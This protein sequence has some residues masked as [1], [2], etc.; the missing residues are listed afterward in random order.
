MSVIVDNLH[1]GYIKQPLCLNGVSFS[2]S[3]NEVVGVL[4]NTGS[5]KTSLLKVLCKLEDQFFGSIS[6]NGKDIKECNFENLDVSFL[7]TAPVLFESKSVLKNIEYLYVV[8]NKPMLEE[9]KIKEVLTKFGLEVDLNA[10]VK[11]LTLTQK[12]LLCFVRAYLKQSS[13]LLIDDQFENIEEK[14]VSKIK[15]AIS[16]LFECENASKSVIMALNL[17]VGTDLCDRFVY[18]S[19]GKSYILNSLSELEE[20][21]VDLFVCNYLNLKNEEVKLIKEN[22]CYYL[23][24]T[25]L[26]EVTKKQFKENIIN[27]IKLSDDFNQ[28]LDKLC[29]DVGSYIKVVLVSKQDIVFDN[30]RIM[31]QDLKSKKVSMF[32]SD[33]GVKILG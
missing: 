13:I 15:N 30:D 31:N 18:L 17:W 10:K 20:S 28:Y 29:L 11:K 6:L 7:P 12:R 3:K 5:G 32:E 23:I 27:Q 4:G 26:V 9:Q 24:K 16:L 33:T 2:A 14:N 1:F 21:K 19:Y 22:N 25:E 8:Q